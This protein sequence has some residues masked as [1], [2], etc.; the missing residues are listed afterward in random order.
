MYKSCLSYLKSK[1]N[2]SITKD[3]LHFLSL[4]LATSEHN[5]PGVGVG[6]KM[7]KVNLPVL[8]KYHTSITGSACN[9]ANVLAHASCSIDT[10][11]LARA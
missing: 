2:R 4:E 5:W 7:L 8:T 6:L 11:I 10:S 9:V 3:W 1:M